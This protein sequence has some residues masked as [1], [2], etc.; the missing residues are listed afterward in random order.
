MLYCLWAI[1]K[2]KIKPEGTNGKEKIK[3]NTKREN[4]EF[5]ER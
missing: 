2:F 1:L 3:Q 4:F 5:Y